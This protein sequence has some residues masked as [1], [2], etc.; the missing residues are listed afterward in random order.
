MTSQD[1]QNLKL[2]PELM[3]LL[4]R[5]LAQAG[6]YSGTFLGSPGKRTLEALDAYL[7]SASGPAPDLVEHLVQLA[8]GE[9]GTK[10][11][12][13]NSGPRIVEYQRATWLE[14]TGWPYCAAF[15]CWLVREAMARCE[16]LAFERPRTAG[17]WDFERWAREQ[18]GKGVR[19]LNSGPVR[20][21]DIV[22]FK[23]SHIGLAVESEKA[24]RVVTVEGNT[25]A[26]GG[27]EGDGV[28]RKSRAKG[29]LRSW[30]RFG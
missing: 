17:A 30:I 20:R 25:G 4:Q 16:G 27:R 15:V 24:G 22:V 14:G 8:L 29:E 28:W 23:I 12:P 10:E 21:G 26:E 3:G 5:G 7:K 2:P 19:L 18:A 11:K 6:Y 13:S 9:V 1:V